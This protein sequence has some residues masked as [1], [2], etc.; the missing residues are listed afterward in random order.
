MDTFLTKS[1]HAI[2][3]YK[4]IEFT[5]DEKNALLN[6]R[7]NNLKPYTVIDVITKVFHRNFTTDLT[8][9][10]YN[11]YEEFYSED[12][13]T[14]WKLSNA[15]VNRCRIIRPESV[16]EQKIENFYVDILADTRIKLHLVKPGCEVLNTDITVEKQYRL[17]YEFNFLPCHLECHFAGV[18]IDEKDSLLNKYPFS[19]RMNKYLLPVFRNADDY[20]MMAKKILLRYIPDQIDS[21]IPLVVTDILENS[22]ISFGF[23]VFS[24]SDVMGEYYF[25]IGYTKVYSPTTGGIKEKIVYPGTIIVNKDIIGNF[26]QLYATIM[27]EFTH[28]E[29][30]FPYLMLQKMHGHDYS[31]YLC[32]KNEFDNENLDPYA[33]MEI[34]ANT[35]PA[36]LFIQDE[37]GKKLAELLF[38][39]YDNNHDIK[40]LEKILDDFCSYFIV[41]KSWGRRRLIDF[42]YKEFGGFAQ[43]AGK[44]PIPNH[45]SGLDKNESYTINE[46]DGIKEYMS[47]PEFR[48]I[49]DT[50]QFIYVEGHY[51]LNTSEYICYDY[52][53]NPH[54]TEKAK[55][56]M[57]ECC[58]VFKNTYINKIIRSSGGVL[59]RDKSSV[60]RKP[61]YMLRDGSSPA[62]AE[63]K[64]LEKMLKKRIRD[65]A[66]LTESFNEMT[67]R[68]MSE[69]RYTIPKLADATG[70]SED[71]IKDLRNNSDKRFQIESVIVVC[72]ALHLPPKISYEYIEKSP[73]KFENGYN[74]M[75][76]RYALDTWYMLT[77]S[78]V[79]RKIVEANGVPLTNLVEGF[80]EAGNEIEM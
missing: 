60:T 57:S 58:L 49:L 33:L 62:T 72:I 4:R 61:R 67:K 76:Y 48:R 21:M 56:H 29:L 53:G 14:G 28:H 51:C 41:P 8:S 38:Q 2:D 12:L 9:Y 16:F 27:H 68:L 43:Y 11:H 17:R 75:L 65:E 46:S 52:F 39:Q 77:V 13:C 80:D 74:M 73:S 50:G 30:C 25:N 24:E 78:Q 66:K 31:S 36:Y 64:A 70:L 40:T 35:L 7:I 79:N 15:W 34:Q 10:V 37:P 45:I 32:R 6:Q 47:N 1:P 18:I 26:T 3:P 63:G 69:R 54:L 44:K 22:G 55:M 5:E 42:G 23:G 20:I 71:T 19:L 59:Y